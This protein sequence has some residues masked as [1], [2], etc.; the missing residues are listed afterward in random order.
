MPAGSVVAIELLC[1]QVENVRA[2]CD[3][4]SCDND[5]YC[6]KHTHKTT[7][8]EVFHEYFQQQKKANLGN[9]IIHSLI[10]GGGNSASLYICCITKSFQK[11]WAECTKLE[12]K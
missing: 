1:C 2:L 12:V 8:V 11:A 5:L 6:C 7:W 9:M 3:L 4:L 10:Q